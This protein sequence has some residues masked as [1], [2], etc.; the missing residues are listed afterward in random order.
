[1]KA[2]LFS[3]VSS[4]TIVATGCLRP[5]LCVGVNRY[6]YYISQ[7]QLRGKREGSRLRISADDVERLIVEQF[8]RWQK[9]DDLVADIATGVWSAETRE[10]ILTTVDRVVIRHDEIEVTFK[11]NAEGSV[12]PSI[13]YDGKSEGQ[14]ILRL[15][16]PPP[17]PRERKEIFVPG[18]SGMKASSDRPG[19]RPSARARKVMDACVTAS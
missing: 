14:N 6:R 19:T 13:D 9:R 10:L 3:A 18:N 11:G 2:A 5:I 8:C 7:A 16:L 1:M 4:S 15:P 17:R 12:A